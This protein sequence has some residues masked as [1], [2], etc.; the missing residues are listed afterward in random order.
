MSVLV[1]S[2]AVMKQLLRNF[3]SVA[4]NLTI[5]FPCNFT[6]SGSQNTEKKPG[7]LTFETILVHS[8]RLGT[9]THNQTQSHTD[10]YSHSHSYLYSLMFAILFTFILL[11]KLRFTKFIITLIF[12]LTRIQIRTTFKF[13]ITLSF[14]VTIKLI[15]T[16]THIAVPFLLIHTLIL[17]PK[18]SDSFS[19]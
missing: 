13:I 17:S 1:F 10:L 5:I 19:N 3:Y 9:Q 14:G 7:K 2:N 15:L 12:L 18:N 4:R 16:L 6:L 8:L 11:H